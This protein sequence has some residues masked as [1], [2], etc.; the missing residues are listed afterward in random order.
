V[1]QTYG[2]TETASQVATLAPDDAAGRPGSAGRA[3]YPNRLR[4]LDPAASDGAGEIA[5]Q[6]PVVMAG[7][8]DRPDETARALRDGWLRTGD[9]GRLDDAGFLYVL[10]RRDDLIVSGGENVYPAEVEA[11][12]LAHPMVVEAGVVGA[13]D[14]AWGQRVVAVVRI[15]GTV[16]HARAEDLLREHCRAALAPYKSPREWRFVTGALPRTA[17]GKLRRSALRESIATR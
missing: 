14:E 1:V 12:L 15:E 4:I 16:D 2:L 13:A 9:I 5:V 7:Y 3:L 11:A 8:L 10:D 17:S 6:G